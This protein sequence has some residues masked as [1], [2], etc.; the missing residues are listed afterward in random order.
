M[1]AGPAT[2]ERR[3]R[4]VALPA[5]GASGPA[6]ATAAGVAPPVGGARF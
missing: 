6:V 2:V 4:V 3:A 1:G 5:T